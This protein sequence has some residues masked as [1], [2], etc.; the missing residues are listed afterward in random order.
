MPASQH[1]RLMGL[2]LVVSPQTLLRSQAPEL[3]PLPH[4]AEQDRAEQHGLLGRLRAPEGGR[5]DHGGWPGL[6]P[7]SCV[8]R[9]DVA[10][11]PGQRGEEDRDSAVTYLW[12]GPPGAPAPPGPG[13][14]TQ[15]RP[16]P[17][18]ELRGGWQGYGGGCCA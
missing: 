2:V 9:L 6:E 13:G 5:R 1:K 3:R 15:P 4:E 11:H 16:G 14:G 10:A 18:E 12:D 7:P 8:R 17:Q